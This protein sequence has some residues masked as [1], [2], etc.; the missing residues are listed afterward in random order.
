MAKREL[1]SKELAALENRPALLEAE[2]PPC[3]AACPVHADV[4]GYLELIASGRFREALELIRLFLPFPSVCGR[5]CHHP[6]EQDCRRGDID[7][8]LAVRDLKRF[9]AEYP[10]PEPLRLDK[11]VQTKQRVA[12]IGG[13]P[14][15]LSAALELARVGYRPVVFDRQK[16]PGGLLASV[17]PPYRLPREV[18]SRDTAAI[19]AQGVEFRGGV[20]IGVDRSFAD[21]VDEGFSAVIIASGLPQSRSLPLPG[22]GASGVH[23][24]LD[25]LAGIVS[26][27]K[28]AIGNDVLVIG[29]GNVAVD[30]A[31]SALRLGAGRVRMACLEN[32]KEQPAWPWE[33]QEAAEEG[34]ETVYRLG[35]N[36]I[37]ERDGRVAGIEFKKVRR[38]FDEAGRFDPRYDE[39]AL[40]TMACDTVILAIGQAADLS[41][42]KGSAVAVDTRGRLVYN[43]DTTQTSLPNIFAAGEVVTGPGSA[44]EAM[45]N[46]KRAARAV[47][48]Y[49]AG[50][51]ID[52]SEM[53]PGKIDKFPAEWLAKHPRLERAAMP[54]AP[55][56]ARKRNFEQFELGY[57][58]DAALAEAHRCLA[59]ASG[60]FVITDKCAACLTCRRVCPF[61]IPLV[62]EVAEI[63]SALCVGCGICAA[64]CPANALVMA[65]WQP[66][67]LRAHLRIALAAAAGGA[68]RLVVFDCCAHTSKSRWGVEEQPPSG[69]LE[70]ALPDLSRLGVQ[71]MLSAF[72]AGADALLLLPCK[73][74][75]GRYPGA[76]ERLLKRAEQAGRLLEEAGIKPALVKVLDGVAG[77][78]RQAAAAIRMMYAEI[79]GGQPA[80]AEQSPPEGDG[81]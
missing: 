41:F 15:G 80:A 2:W 52:L 74:G 35:P 29:G 3:R 49:L 72:E 68:K 25:F 47:M 21:L 45:A 73:D 77:D 17:I 1:L 67:E 28:P 58:E 23:L 69:V 75:A 5:I 53:L 81:R 12:I 71:D 36:R 37:I 42:L 40:S 32:E 39:A 18:L 50:S 76:D 13:G 7:K 6:C 11:P 64:E 24:A 30:V 34:V 38:V 10:Y 62:K 59:C 70:V 22:I 66:E 27:R 19:L 8:P 44:V 9:V 16:T 46:G 43:R 57:S 54:I 4:R 65:G 56:E 55:A 33:K 61:E 60:P 78:A 79:S 20:E 26:G 63:S 14:G 51:P 31:R 48:Q